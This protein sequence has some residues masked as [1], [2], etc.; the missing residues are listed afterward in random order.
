MMVPRYKGTP[1]DDSARARLVRMGLLD[2]E[3][4]ADQDAVSVLARVYAGLFYDALCDACED[5]ERV[6]VTCS[7]LIEQLG[8]V[9]PKQLFLSICAQHDYIHRDLPE[10]IWRISGNPTVVN[11]FSEDFVRRLSEFI[12]EGEA[13]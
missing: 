13:M 1:F 4:K 3:G 6:F 12:S 8:V 9:T 11:I 7:D 5:K 10:P 2:E